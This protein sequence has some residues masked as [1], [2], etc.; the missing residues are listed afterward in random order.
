MYEL[1][2]EMHEEYN[3]LKQQ[4]DLYKS[5]I[6]EVREYINKYAWQEDIIGGI[7]TCDGKPATDRYM[8]LEWDYCNELLEILDK[9][10]VG[11]KECL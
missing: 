3:E 7:Y 8:R 10:K 1:I 9:A 6:E 5:V 4:R 11:D 2:G